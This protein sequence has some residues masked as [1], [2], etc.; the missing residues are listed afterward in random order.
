VNKV[1]KVK[2]AQRDP[3]AQIQ[4]LLDQLDPQA[5]K[6]ML[7]TTDPLA[8][9]EYKA[10]L[11]TQDPLA[12][13]ARRDPQ[14]HRGIQAQA[15]QLQIGVRFGTRQLKLL[16]LLIRHKSS[17]SIHLTLQTVV[18]LSFQTVV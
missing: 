6:E 3:Q 2:L 4:L 10:T 18:S 1:F 12:H 7:V 9:R 14:A 16:S 11:A 5:N 15:A 17:Q 13:K 8:H